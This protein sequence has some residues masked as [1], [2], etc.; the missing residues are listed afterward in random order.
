MSN[1]KH[2]ICS[3]GVWDSTMPGISFDENGVSNYAKLQ[4][5]LMEDFPKN[6]QSKHFWEN[7]V[8]TMKKQGKGKKYDCIIGISG[9]TDSCYLLHIAKEYGLRPLAVNLDNG[10][11][12]DISVSNIKKVTSALNID[13]ETYVINYEEVKDLLRTYMKASLPWIDNPS[14][15]A[16]AASLYKTAKREGIKN[17]LTGTDF[18]SEGKQPTEWTYSDYKQLKYLHKQ[19]GIHK[20]K[21]FPLM[22]LKDMV[23]NRYLR[24]IKKVLPYNY[25]QYNKQDAQHLL[26]KQY[27]W[28]YYGGHHHENI[29]TK[30]VIGYWMPEKFNID[31]RKITL[32]AQILSGVISRDEA[33]KK[34]KEPPYPKENI[35]RDTDYIIKK[36]SLSKREF[37]N[38][39]NEPNKF[40]YDYP[41]YYDSIKKYARFFMPLIVKITNSKPKFFYEM[42]ARES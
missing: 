16:I 18:R 3:L 22:S 28:E 30:W 29:F 12:S 1:Y 36:L 17:I 33:L 9:G 25:I 20:I 27:E 23:F 2:R 11:N 24:G 34:L 21:T 32:S 42:E 4:K 7:T 35:T 10:F 8:E 31:K 38:I 14:D 6:Q 39:W 41:S 5:K 15:Q 13:L 40:F 37:G 19:F 26:K